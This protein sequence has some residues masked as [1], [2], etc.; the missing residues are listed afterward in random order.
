MGICAKEKLP[1]WERLWDDCIQEETRTE[2]ISGKQGGGAT[3]DHLALVS[4]IKKG[5]KNIVKKVDSQG[6]GQQSR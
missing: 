6:E 2:S 1:K 3:D 5:N 4:K